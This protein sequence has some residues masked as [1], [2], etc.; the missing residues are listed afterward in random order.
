M[1]AA[2]IFVPVTFVLLLFSSNCKK[3]QPATTES[4]DKNAVQQA[5]QGTQTAEPKKEEGVIAVVNGVKIDAK[6]FN[7]RVEKLTKSGQRPI[8]DERLIKIKENILK[9]MISDELMNQAIKKEGVALSDEELNAAVDEYKKRFNT[10]EQFA[11]Y[12]EHSKITMEDIKERVKSQKL[13]EKLLEKLGL[14]TVTD[15]EA[16]DY[17]S[18]NER[19]YTEKEKIKASQILVKCAEEPTKEEEA[20]AKKK[21]KEIQA[22]LKKEDFAEVAKK[23]SDDDVTKEKGGDLGIVIRGTKPKEFEDAAFA[24]NAGQVTANPVKT[25]TGYLLIKV[26]EKTPEAKKPFEEVKNDIIRSLKSTKFFKS[27]RDYIDKLT[28]EAKIEKSI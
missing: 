18:K 12:L 21:I 28:S 27:K 5:A 8:P 10:E 16:K 11:K 4:P 1:N 25:K 26:F 22:A 15:E 14:Y 19:F 24:L 3:E 13:Q 7:E 2:K 6:P 9:Q 23:F 20:A 17:Y